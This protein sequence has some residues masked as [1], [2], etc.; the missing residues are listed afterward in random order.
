MKNSDDEVGRLQKLWEFTENF[1]TEKIK[2]NYKTWKDKPSELLQSQLSPQ[3]RQQINSCEGVFE[4]AVI[5][6]QNR[7]SL[8]NVIGSW[9]G[10][11]DNLSGVLYGFSPHKT[12]QEYGSD[13]GK[14]FNQIKMQFPEKFNENSRFKAKDSWIKFCSHVLSA[15]KFLAQFDD[16]NTFQYWATSLYNNPLSKGALPLILQNE[17]DGFGYALSC[18]FLKELGFTSFGKPDVHIKEIFLGVGFYQKQPSDYQTQKYILK[19][20]DANG[21]KPFVVDKYFWLVGS[22]KFFLNPSLV[23]D[24]KTKV[25]TNKNNIILRDDGRIGNGWKTDFIDKFM[26]ERKI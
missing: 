18:D 8:P 24:L 15:A 26:S 20:A 16:E 6:L 10:G 3:N 19:I 7:F 1:L 4:R 14:L 25:N 21:V 17:I 11:I 9:I 13:E 12:F 23:P 22:G 5:S 2:T